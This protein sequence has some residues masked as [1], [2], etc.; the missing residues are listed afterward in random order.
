[1]KP[2]K[3]APPRIARGM[4]LAG[5]RTL[6]TGAVAFSKP[7]NAN[8]ASV[9]AEAM[10]G[11]VIGLL[12]SG[13]NGAPELLR[14]ARMTTTASRGTSLIATVSSDKPPEVRTPRRLTRVRMKTDPTPTATIPDVPPNAGNSREKAEAVAIASAAWAAMF[15]HQKAQVTRKAAA[16]PNARSM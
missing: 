5:S 7:V 8:R 9:V 11:R 16:G 12:A 10:L 13:S 3:A 4:V 14:I 15:D 2:T 6:S 1:M